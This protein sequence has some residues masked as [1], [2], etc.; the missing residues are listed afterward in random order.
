[1]ASHKGINGRP[2]FLGPGKS[3]SAIRAIRQT[4]FS[5]FILSIPFLPKF[6]RFGISS[7]DFWFIIGVIIACGF[8][9][10]IVWRLVNDWK[11]R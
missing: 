8:V 10:V 3:G 7:R 2:F 9:V 5:P 6:E 1:M 11:V 4:P